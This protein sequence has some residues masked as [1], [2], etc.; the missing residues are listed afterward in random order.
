MC[1]TF[2]RCC[3]ISCN[4]SFM[5]KKDKCKF[6]RHTI[7]FLAYV[8]SPNGVTIDQAKVTTINN[9]PTHRTIKKFL[10]FA[11]FDYRFI[12]GFRTIAHPLTSL[13]KKGTPGL[14]SLSRESLSAT[15]D[16]VHHIIHI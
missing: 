3:N 16:S 2:D 1:T 11:N 12:Q 10:G 13:L 15:Q 14:E 8:M 9:W 5:L 6:H 7:S 4:I